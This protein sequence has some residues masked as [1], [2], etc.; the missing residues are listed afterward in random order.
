MAGSAQQSAPLCPHGNS[1]ILRALGPPAGP[2]LPAAAVPKAWAT[3]QR[4][5]NA[6]P[7]CRLQ[8]REEDPG[9]MGGLWEQGIGHFWWAGSMQQVLPQP[10]ALRCLQPT[11][12]S[13]A[14]VFTPA[15]SGPCPLVLCTTSHCSPEPDFGEP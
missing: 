10:Q 2:L 3:A 1:D 14:E 15:P 8:G 5:Q 4:Q 13:S 9:S 12:Q 7:C 6:S 11:P